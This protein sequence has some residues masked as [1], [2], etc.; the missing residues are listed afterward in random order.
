MYPTSVFGKEKNKGTLQSLCKIAL[1][2]ILLPCSCAT[3]S[4]SGWHR[5]LNV[6]EADGARPALKGVEDI[7]A[8][9]AK[10][11]VVPIRSGE[12]E[13][14]LSGALNLKHPACEQVA[15]ETLRVPVF[16]YLLH[17]ERFGYFLIDSGSSTFY[18]GEPYG[19]MGGILVPRVM[20]KTFVES[21]RETIGMQLREHIDSLDKINGVFFTH[22]HFDHTS[23]LSDLPRPLYFV[24]GRGESFP[25]IPW[26][27]EPRHFSGGDHIYLL[28]FDSPYA[29][30]REPGR[31]ID[32]FGDGTLWAISTP[33]HSKGHV[34]YLV[35]TTSGPVLV[36]GDAV[37]LNR[38]LDLGV[39]P[40]AFCSNVK[41]AQQSFERIAA[42]KK[43]HPEIKIWPGHDTP[44]E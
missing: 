10:I 39:G 25:E 16:A 17:H 9:R 23:G 7:F 22:L 2:L 15:D 11:T 24:A 5:S 31:M 29:A 4:K 41:L 6:Y 21:E 36:A 20:V 28:D 14:K 13:I 42:F 33:G 8:A 12:L 35:N 27:V 32:I 18:V 30:E 40:G 37:I 43:N 44:E 1:L 3:F 34:S 38:S 26:L 19:P